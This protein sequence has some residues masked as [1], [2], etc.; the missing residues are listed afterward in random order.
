MIALLFDSFFITEIDQ[1]LYNPIKVVWTSSTELICMVKN[2]KNGCQLCF[3]HSQNQIYKSKCPSSL[4]CTPCL[5]ALPLILLSP[6]GS[7]FF[8]L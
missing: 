6:S 7:A 1:P 3:D 4:C 2:Y 5:P 8:Y